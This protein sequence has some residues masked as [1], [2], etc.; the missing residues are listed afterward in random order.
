MARPVRSGIAV[1]I[2]CG[3]I[4]DLTGVSAKGAFPLAKAVNVLVHP[5]SSGGSPL[6]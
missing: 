1:N 4:G 6:S 5:G 3:R 2:L